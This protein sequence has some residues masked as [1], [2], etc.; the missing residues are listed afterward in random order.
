M[1]A[2]YRTQVKVGDC[3][4]LTDKSVALGGHEDLLRNHKR[5]NS[6]G[7]PRPVAQFGKSVLY[8][9]SELDAFYESV[10]WR[11]SNAAIDRYMGA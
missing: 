10:M 7:F 1:N 6:T 11:S 4:T 8:V 5:N 9:E 2:V 3:I